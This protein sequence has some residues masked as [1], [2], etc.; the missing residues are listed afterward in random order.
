MKLAIQ[1]PYFYPYLGY[2]ELIKSVD[3]FVFF[4]DVQYVRRSWI[5]RNKISNDFYLTVPINKCAQATNINKIKINYDF[6]WHY[7]HC[8]SI[9]SK[10]GKKCMNNPVYLFYKNIPKYEY[11]F[12]LLR[13]S[14]K[15]V[16]EFFRIKTEFIDSEIFEIEKTIKG[17]ERIVK[18]CNLLGAKE[19]YN[20]PRGANLYNKEDFVHNGID[21]KFINIEKIN[22][23]MSILDT[24]LS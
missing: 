4:N 12:D 13:D 9:E 8:R 2:F 16:C 11:L 15:N 22:N 6:N 24:C 19:Y 5:N 18:I 14:I 10:Y 1:Q 7:K 3:V 23:F 21:I 20:L 17:K